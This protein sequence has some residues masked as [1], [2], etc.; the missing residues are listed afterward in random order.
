MIFLLSCKQRWHPPSNWGLL[1]NSSN[2]EILEQSLGKRCIIRQLLIGTIAFQCPVQAKCFQELWKHLQAWLSISHASWEHGWEARRGPT[3][4][5]V[6][7]RVALTCWVGLWPHNSRPA[8]WP[9][10]RADLGSSRCSETTP[11]N[12]FLSLLSP[13]FLPQVYKLVQF[14]SKLAMKL[15]FWPVLSLWCFL[16]AF[17]HL[18]KLPPPPWRH[19]P[20]GWIGFSPLTFLNIVF[21]Q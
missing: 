21:S 3:E 7:T 1:L 9:H 12:P 19:F 20:Y 15:C 8:G 11:S 13:A 5:W 16:H 6:L 18:H 17:K 4:F 14:P 10:S 2:K